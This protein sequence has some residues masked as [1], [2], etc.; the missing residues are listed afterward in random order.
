[1]E[2]SLSDNLIIPAHFGCLL[3]SRLK[4]EYIPYD[5][6][7]T[8][9]LKH[10]VDD[11]IFSL[12]HDLDAQV[13]NEQKKTFHL[14]GKKLGFLNKKGRFKGKCINAKPPEAHLLGPLTIHLSITN[15]CD[16]K[17]T[18]CFASEE[19]LQGEENPLTLK[20]MDALFKEASSMGCMRTALTGG[21][22]LNRPEVFEIIDSAAG[23]GIDTCLTTNGIRLNKETV[24]QI[25]KRPFAWVNVSLEGATAE[26]NDAV[27]GKGSFNQVTHNIKKHLKWRV[28]FSLSIT[29]NRINTHEIPMFQ[30]LARELGAE[31]IM[32]RGCYPIG[33]AAHDDN[34]CMSLT[35]YEDAISALRNSSHNIQVVP[36]SCE[37]T[38]IKELAIIFDNFGCAAGN[39]VA[40]VL[41]DGNVSPCSLITGGMEL[42]NI[43]DKSFKEIWDSGKAFKKIRSIEAPELCKGCDSLVTCSGG[44]RA[45]AWSAHNSLSEPD[46]WCKMLEKE[47]V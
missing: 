45:R 10:S 15:S 21:E 16:L 47:T 7:T 46:S 23:H 36:S 11:S 29:L 18:H 26:T 9:I 25:S 13:T 28:P 40:T 2:I 31:S 5:Q 33:A 14:L 17:C 20:E 22:P 30:K 44:C 34:L 38:D 4:N 32:L 43:R 19:M 24:K 37:A 41:T 42:E 3:Y 12:P 35:E 27:R 6:I 8:S 1:M 39:T